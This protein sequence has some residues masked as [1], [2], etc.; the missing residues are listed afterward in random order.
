MEY[1]ISFYSTAQSGSSA[2]RN[3]ENRKRAADFLQQN[4]FT[5]GEVPH[6][7]DLQQIQS[8]LRTSFGLRNTHLYGDN[9]VVAEDPQGSIIGVGRFYLGHIFHTAM[10]HNKLDMA[11]LHLEKANFAQLYVLPQ[12][13]SQGVGKAIVQR[14]VKEAQSQGFKQIYG[15]ADGDTAILMPLYKGLGFTIETSDQPESIFGDFPAIIVNIRSGGFF[16]QMPLQPHSQCP[17]KRD[18]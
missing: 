7:K 5:P 14:A 11:Q 8:E 3:L 4:G 1:Q 9:V 17:L 13:R 10:Q 16:F 2:T 12:A 18:C 6:A 15:Y